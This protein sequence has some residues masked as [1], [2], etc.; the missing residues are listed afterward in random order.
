MT[1]YE[2]FSNMTTGGFVA[3]IVI[4]LSL[5]EIVPVKISPLGWIGKRINRE[6]SKQ[7]KDITDQVAKV[8]KKL[9]EHVAQSYRN[10]IL[11]FQ[12]DVIAGK[13]KSKEQWKEV[14]NAITAYE[15]YCEVNHISNGL[16]KEAS[17]MLLTEYRNTLKA[18]GFM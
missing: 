7:V 9:D 6:I 10:K 17:R 12:D 15:D 13:P 2:V 11:T 3:G 4:I 18:N 8:E 1:I 5:I 16:C 14:V